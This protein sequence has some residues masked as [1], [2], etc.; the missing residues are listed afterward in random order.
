MRRSTYHIEFREHSASKVFEEDVVASSQ[1]DAY[2]TFMD[3]HNWS[4]YSAWVASVTYQNGKHHV[5][6]KNI[7]GNPY[8]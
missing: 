2:M 6:N 5:F 1:Y 4:V 8:C 7:E 3:A